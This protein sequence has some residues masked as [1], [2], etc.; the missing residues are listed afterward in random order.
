M[1]AVA[2]EPQTLHA[3]ASWR[4]IRFRRGEWCP[5]PDAEHQCIRTCGCCFSGAQSGYTWA[6]RDRPVPCLVFG[7]SKCRS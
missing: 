4:F 5:S 6:Q 7:S 3:S 1:P 2:F